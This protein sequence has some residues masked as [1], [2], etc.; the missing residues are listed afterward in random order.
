MPLI[1]TTPE[2]KVAYGKD[3]EEV[4]ELLVGS[5]EPLERCLGRLIATGITETIDQWIAAE[6]E[7]DSRPVDLLTAMLNVQ[8]SLFARVAMCCTRPG[9]EAALVA[10]MKSYADNLPEVMAGYRSPVMDVTVDAPSPATKKGPSPWL[11][12]ES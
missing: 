9:G 7:R 6:V 4:M 10:T 5:K 1:E 12:Q 3:A 11:T 8:L 2:H